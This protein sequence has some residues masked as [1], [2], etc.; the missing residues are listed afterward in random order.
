MFETNKDWLPLC[1]FFEPWSCYVVKVSCELA[2][3]PRL[4]L[5]SSCHNLL[6]AVITCVPPH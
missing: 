5:K 4:A 3:Q 6:S 1:M 2:M